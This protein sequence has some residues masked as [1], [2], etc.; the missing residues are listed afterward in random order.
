[1]G[2]LCSIRA[3]QYQGIADEP[4]DPE[5]QRLKEL[6]FEVFPDG[7]QRETCLISP[8]SGYGLTGSARSTSTK[9]LR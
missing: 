4:V 7:H 1:M 2:A 6:Y 3:S 8:T 9:I 5:L